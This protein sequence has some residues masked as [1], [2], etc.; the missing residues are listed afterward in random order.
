MIAIDTH[1]HVV[2]GLFIDAIRRGELADAI[3]ISRRGAVEHFDFHPPPGVPVE[4]D[5]ALQAEMCDENLIIAA[6]DARDLAAAA[7][8]P[9]PEM[10][11]DWARPETG[12]R[13]AA[14]MNAGL[15]HLARNHPG[16]LYGL[17]A[18][19]M[20]DG[21][22][23]ALELARAVGELGLRG[24]AI[25]THVNGVDLDA[26]RFAPL[27]HAAERLQVPLFL[28]PQNHGDL[29]RLQDHHLWNLVGF[30]FETAL[31]T[32][33][34]LLAGVFERH[35]DLRVI[36]AHGGGFFPYQIGRLDHGWRSRPALRARLSHPPS[37]YLKNIVCDSLVHDAASLR[38]LV[39]RI[40]WDHVVLGCDYPFGMGANVPVAAVRALRLPAAQD[41][42]I[43]GG[44][45]GALL[46]IETQPMPEA[47]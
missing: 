16:R 33:R 36:L 37:H 24:A 46:Q 30:P 14:A 38:F 27:F 18:L 44:T 17:A 47:P 7:I 12:I 21:E 31:T 35:P 34:L 32:A 23:A 1:F 22:A 13:I 15:A 25:C 43:L 26:V 3:T 4:P 20:H 11:M 6:L 42:A 29:R 8:S 28:H 39:E 19:P 40:G 9:A 41:A 45:L 10:F 5:T 2:P